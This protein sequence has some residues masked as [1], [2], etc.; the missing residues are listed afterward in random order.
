MHILRNSF[1]IFN[2]YR[3]ANAFSP[4]FVPD[5]QMQELTTAISVFIVFWNAVSIPGLSQFTG[6]F[7]GVGLSTWIVDEFFS[8][9]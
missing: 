7:I 2:Y 3:R 1:S 5:G 4:W 6:F 8:N 9:D